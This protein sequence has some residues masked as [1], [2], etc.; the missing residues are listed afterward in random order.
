MEGEQKVKEGRE[1]VGGGG[2]RCLG[3][4]DNALAPR[5]S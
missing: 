5:P 2:G 4:E 3:E 1:C